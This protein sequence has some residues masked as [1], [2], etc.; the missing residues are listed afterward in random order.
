[1]KKRLAGCLWALTGVLVVLL[2]VKLYVVDV[3]RVDS[4]SMRPTIFG[5]QD[6][7]GGGRLDEH[8]LVRYGRLHDLRRFDLVVVRGADGEGLV[9]RVVGLPFETVH[10]AGGDLFIDSAPIPSGAPRPAPVPVFDSQLQDVRD[11]FHFQRAPDGPWTEAGG[12]WRLDAREIPIGGEA[13]M[14]LLHE[15]LRDGYLDEHGAPVRGTRQVNDGIVE[16]EVRAERASGRVRLRLVEQGDTFEAQLEHVA[17]GRFR[18]LIVRHNAMT[19]SAG[20]DAE[21][22]PVLASGDVDFA[23]GA[24]HRLAF[25]NVDDHLELALDGRPVLSASY[26][27]NLVHPRP[28]VAAAGRTVGAQVALGAEACE[29]S[30]RAI[31]VLRDPYWRARGDFAVDEPLSLG[32]NEVF[33]LGDNSS[34]SRDSRDF[35]PVDLDELLGTPIWVVWPPSRIRPLTGA[36][37]R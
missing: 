4:P 13:G 15:E 23:S 18:A 11:A 10:V 12:V 2:L 9:K 26:D 22:Q 32:R 14:L 30:F 8:V 21:R 19:Q 36:E 29:A 33:V 28:E 37:E 5:G 27:G 3:Y 17:D 24:W 35:G 20:P 25:S 31:R 6:P 34:H 7:R 16:C 1:M